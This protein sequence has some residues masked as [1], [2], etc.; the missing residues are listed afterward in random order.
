[1]RWVAETGAALLFLLLLLLLLMLLLLLLRATPPLPG[2]RKNSALRPNP[3]SFVSG[4][5]RSWVIALLTQMVLPKLFA[6]SGLV[7]VRGKHMHCA[8]KFDTWLGN[9]QATRDDQHAQESDC[10]L[11][12]D[13]FLNKLRRARLQCCASHKDHRRRP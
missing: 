2:K 5:A 4:R 10:C 13:I 3:V 9:F 11:Q 6:I 12:A 8:P 7:Q 1:M